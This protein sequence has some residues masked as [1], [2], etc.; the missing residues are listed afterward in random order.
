MTLDLRS[1]FSIFRGAAPRR[2]HLAAHSHHFWPDRACA[3][4]A[5][6]VT[7]AA[8]SADNKWA[9]I[10]ADLVPRVQR[11]IARVLN[12]PDARTIAVA[13]NTHELLCRLI[14]ALPIDRP[15]RIL[16]SDSEFHSFERQIARLQQENLVSVERVPTA[17]SE[18]FPERFYAAAAR[19]RYE[20]V[21]VSQVFFNS[22]A[23]AGEL[24][25]IVTAVHSPDTFIAIDGYHGFMALPTDLSRLA[26]RAFY[27]AGGY[28]Y[29]MAGE[30]ACFLHCPPG[31]A[32]RP[33]DTGW[34]AGFG[35]LTEDR[36]PLAY[37]SDGSRFLGATFDPSGLHRLAAVFDWMDE[38]GL[39][40]A[41]IHEHV[42]AL[43]AMFLA[44]IDAARVQVLRDARLVTPVADGNRGH[45]LTFEIPQARSIHDRLAASDIVTD[46]RGSR[47]RFGFGCYH[48]ADEIVP[49]VDAIARA[50]AS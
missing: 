13:P 49:A 19:Q 18:N 2:I 6:A 48:A 45:F 29:A 32:P 3:A 27:L 7:E 35:E 30:G 47:I 31:Y 15:P 44:A 40:V 37:A 41:A 24:E 36:G 28:K 14:S 50:L 17:P 26:A 8:R 9:A 25:A 21:F 4:H 16:T 46:V 34:F 33:R 22:G 11:G 20:L 38:I 39:S 42:M 43:Q 1:H 10:F 12:L 23:S 5:N